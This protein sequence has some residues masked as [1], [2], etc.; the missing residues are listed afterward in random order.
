NEDTSEPFC[1]VSLIT[2]P[3]EEEELV[4]TSNK[5]ALKL[6][7]NRRN[8]RYPYSSNSED[9]LLKNL[10][11]FD[12]L[13]LRYNR[14]ILF[15]KDV[16]GNESFYANGCKIARVCCVPIT[17]NNGRNETKVEFPETRI[18][19]E[20]RNI[21]R[22]EPRDGRG[23]DNALPEATGGAA[24]WAPHLDEDVP[25]EAWSRPFS[26]SER[27]QTALP[28]ASR[29]S[30]TGGHAMSTCSLIH[31]PPPGGAASLRLAGYGH[32]FARS[33][34]CDRFCCSSLNGFA[35]C[36]MEKSPN[37]LRAPERAS[38]HCSGA[39]LLKG[40]LLLLWLVFGL[41]PAGTPCLT[42]VG[43][44][45]LPS[46]IPY[47][48][49]LQPP[50]PLL[51]Q[52]MP[53]GAAVLPGIPARTRCTSSADLRAGSL[54]YT[55]HQPCVCLPLVFTQEGVA[56]SEQGHPEQ[57]QRQQPHDPSQGTWPRPS[58]LP[59][60]QH[61]GGADSRQKP[62]TCGLVTGAAEWE[63]DEDSVLRDAAQKGQDRALGSRAKASPAPLVPAA[64]RPPSLPLSRSSHLGDSSPHRSLLAP[65]ASTVLL[66]GHCGTAQHPYTAAQLRLFTQA[67]L[68][69]G[70]ALD[71]LMGDSAAV[72][73]WPGTGP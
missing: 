56:V 70:L 69:L 14:R 26:S 55:Q 64:G 71:S 29:D 30:A 43:G 8:S 51:A 23:P 73:C 1:K 24:G 25:M 40:H 61:V 27:P 63:G 16:T 58:F 65:R 3:K 47:C 18:Y 17:C 46:S 41:V 37:E 7:Y 9:N 33:P 59:E 28:P 21:L 31:D 60:P 15:I 49:P 22:L 6:L 52:P 5:P 13:S 50:S 67:S 12:Q 42:V 44:G 2:S 11:L 66:R 35:T 19:E 48:C 4:R 68:S 34:F 36:H 72:S 20:I 45:A 10:E 53:R 57:E 54:L 39:W 38:W 62:R 32:D